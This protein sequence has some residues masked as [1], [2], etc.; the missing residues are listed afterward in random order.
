MEEKI[1]VEPAATIESITSA[2]AA[3]ADVLN[4]DK[5]TKQQTRKSDLS[6]PKPRKA[7]RPRGW[8]RMDHTGVLAFAI[9]SMAMAHT[10]TARRLP[11]CGCSPPSDADPAWAAQAN[12]T[13]RALFADRSAG[14]PV[15]PEEFSKISQETQTPTLPGENEKVPGIGLDRSSRWWGALRAADM[16]KERMARREKE[17]IK[18]FSSGKK[19]KAEKEDEGKEDWKEKL[20]KT[21]PGKWDTGC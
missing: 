6:G 5:K 14:P 11:E 8:R 15:F 20:E 18:A 19:R 9:R 10:D 1:Q 17:L 13:S 12:L 21:C 2:G 3:G 16:A 4:K 7:R